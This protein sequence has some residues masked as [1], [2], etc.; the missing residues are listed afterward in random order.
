MSPL[1]TVHWGRFSLALFGDKENRPQWHLALSLQ[2]GE[3][4]SDNQED[5]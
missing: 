4:D 1:G 5:E 3:E 2:E